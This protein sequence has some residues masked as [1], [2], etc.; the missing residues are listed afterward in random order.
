M[1]ILNDSHASTQNWQRSGSVSV[2]GDRIELTPASPAGQIGALWNTLPNPYTDW[3]VEFEFRAQGPN[4]RG[5]RGLAFWYT[6]QVGEPGVVF[7]NND[8]WDGLGLFI[9]TDPETG[10]G[11]IRGH[12]NDG[13]L[14]YAQAEKPG[15]TA[16][17]M[18]SF[19]YRNLAVPTRISVQ[20][21]A[22]VF[23]VERDGDLCFENHNVY[24]PPRMNFGITAQT[25]ESP[26]AHEIHSYVLYPIQ[27]HRTTASGGSGAGEVAADT[28]SSTGE[29]RAEAP[30]SPRVEASLDE[31]KAALSQLSDLGTAVRGLQASM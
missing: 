1:K 10:E 18:C 31:I 14:A 13:N 19:N 4:R 29:K 26:D 20:Y 17:G 9:G 15:S 22:N 30:I 2:H 5:G 6:S 7:G 12:L 27:V 25:E 3:K 21:F 8:R 16:F 23:R 11:E 28:S 24:L